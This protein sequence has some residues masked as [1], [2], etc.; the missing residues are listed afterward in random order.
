MENVVVVSR[1]EGTIKL[2]KK[3]FP[4]A[5]VIDHLNDVSE[6]PKGSLVIG[7]LPLPMIEEILKRG[8]RFVIVSL[9]IPRELRG[10]ELTEEELKKFA[11]FIEVEDLKLKKF[12]LP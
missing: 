3:H 1:H 4:D 2:L 12:R 5:E 8:S 10:K 6:I 9:N 11:E 7:N